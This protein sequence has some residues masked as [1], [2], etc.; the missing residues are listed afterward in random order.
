MMVKKEENM[1]IVVNGKERDYENE[2]I[3][4][5]ELLE[6][7]DVQAPDMV[8]VQLNRDFVKREDFDTT[9]IRA[10]DKIDFLYFM[11]GGGSPEIELDIKT[12]VLHNPGEER[13]NNFKTTPPPIYQATSF[14]YSDPEE[15]AD[16][17]EG[18]RFGYTYTRMGN[19]TVTAFERKIAGMEGGA[20]A[21]ATSSGM[22]AITSVVF[23]LTSQGD[24]IISSGSLFG[25]TLS[26]FNTLLKK[27]GVTVRYVEGCDVQAYEDAV[28]EK[29]KM[30]FLETI[31]N[32]RI[33][34]PDVNKI[35]GMT[36]KY[37]LPLVVDSTVTTP[38][39]FNARKHGVSVVVHSATKYI[40]GN[41]SSIGGLIVDTGKFDWST[42]DSDE[43]K[44]ERNKV[45][46][47]F[48]FLSVTKRVTQDTGMCLSPFNAYLHNLGLETLPLRMDAHCRNAMELAHFLQ[49]HPKTSDVLYPGL[50]TSEHNATAKSQFYGKYGGIITIRFT[51]R[52]KCFKFI[53]NLKLIKNLANIGDSRTLII[54]PDSTIYHSL[55][56]SVKKAAGV[57]ERVV[58]IS[59]GI[60]DIQDIINDVNQALEEV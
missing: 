13:N 23:S 12:K 6:I 32:P 52:D 5:K 16:V 15:I 47:R 9:E 51:D 26:L 31:G 54:H 49:K 57:D 59:V 43:Y 4:V 50:K 44:K 46:S 48:L 55:P 19:P 53:R 2:G 42:L 1:K 41:G 40:T 30:V 24:E 8:S 34:V 45:D 39:L 38:Y 60:E 33:D 20:G 10:G 22:A 36:Q 58:R 17:F 35:S 25:G 21:I 27:Y 56:E 3:T 14:E 29:T 28:T 7:N 18:R 11:G 37:N